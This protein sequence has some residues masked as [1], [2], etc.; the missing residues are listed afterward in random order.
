MQPI[1]ASTLTTRRR[2][3]FG[4]RT[5]SK[6]EWAAVQTLNDATDGNIPAVRSKPPSPHPSAAAAGGNRV[7][8]L[9]DL[10][11]LSMQSSSGS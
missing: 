7:L 3:T 6:D 4:K 2:V 9:A 8:V 5:L 1:S 10:T 11:R